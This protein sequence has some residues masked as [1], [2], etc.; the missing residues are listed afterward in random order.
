MKIIFDK[1]Q[2]EPDHAMSKKDIKYLLDLVPEDWLVKFNTI[3]FSNQVFNKKSL[4]KRPVNLDEVDKKLTILSRGL[5]KDETAEQIMIELY[6]NL[7]PGESLFFSSTHAAYGSDLSPCQ[8]KEIR[9]KIA[10]YLK[11]WQKQQ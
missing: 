2:S 11:K 4:F 1:I 10:P 8:L 3:H 9:K 7:W 5:T 6:Q